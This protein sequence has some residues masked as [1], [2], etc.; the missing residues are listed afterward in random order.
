MSS[1]LFFKNSATKQSM[2]NKRTLIRSKHQSNNQCPFSSTVK[3]VIIYINLLGPLWIN[4]CIN[5]YQW[6]TTKLVY[7]LLGIYT[8]AL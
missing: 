8:K 2:E 7:D 5:V 3:L 4:C 1:D 6:L